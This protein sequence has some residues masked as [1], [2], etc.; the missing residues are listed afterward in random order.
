[1]DDGEHVAISGDLLFGAIARGDLFGDQCVESFVTGRD[2]L[3]AIRA[4]VLWIRA[5]FVSVVSTSGRMPVLAF[6]RPRSS[7][8]AV[9][10]LVV[11]GVSSPT[12]EAM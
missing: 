4:S 1:M 7:W 9:S 12:A 6:C 8:M 2:A 3:D 11:R 5:M 10:R